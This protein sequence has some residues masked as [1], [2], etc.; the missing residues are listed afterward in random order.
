MIFEKFYIYNLNSEPGEIFSR[1]SMEDHEVLVLAESELPSIALMACDTIELGL[2]Y[3]LAVVQFVIV[4]AH[5]APRSNNS[6][7][8]CT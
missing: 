3:L 6:V 5:F 2:L 4:L 1:V 7:I 8:Q